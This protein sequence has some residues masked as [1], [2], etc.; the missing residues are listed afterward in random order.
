MMRHIVERDVDGLH[1]SSGQTRLVSWLCRLR[2]RRGE[3]KC[4]LEISIARRSSQSLRPK[5]DRSPV[6]TRAEVQEAKLEC[7]VGDIR[8][9]ELTATRRNR[10]TP[11]AR[12]TFRHSLPQP[13]A[14]CAG[15]QE[16]SGEAGAVTPVNGSLAS[17]V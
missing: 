15:G 16:S 9:D 6:N 7:R 13:H 14:A 4:N 8:V 12:A 2:R 3:R 17:Y 5:C 11:I 1:V 10:I